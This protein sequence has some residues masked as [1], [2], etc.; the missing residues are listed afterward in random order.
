[1]KQAASSALFADTREF[2]VGFGVRTARD[3]EE[4]CLFGY[5]GV[6]F[7]ESEPMF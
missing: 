6:Y 4:H 7:V 2:T 5:N 1:M 3:Y